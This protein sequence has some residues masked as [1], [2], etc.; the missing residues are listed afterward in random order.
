MDENQDVIQGSVAAGVL[1]CHAQEHANADVIRRAAAKIMPALSVTKK[2]KRN[3][4]VKW[5]I[6][7]SSRNLVNDFNPIQ[8]VQPVSLCISGWSVLKTI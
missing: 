8:F 4:T 1:D 5:G 3:G 7:R 2:R 6:L